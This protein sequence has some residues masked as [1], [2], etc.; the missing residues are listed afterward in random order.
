MLVYIL[1]ICLIKYISDYLYE[2]G[3]DIFWYRYLVLLVFVS[4]GVLY[5]GF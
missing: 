5:A 3:L 2:D 1:I 4:S